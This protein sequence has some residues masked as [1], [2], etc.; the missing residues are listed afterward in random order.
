MVLQEL[1]GHLNDCMMGLRGAKNWEEH[2][3]W[4][5]RI[6]LLEEMVPLRVILLEQ[7]AISKKT[8]LDEEEE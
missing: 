6:G 3:H 7:D 4:M 5:S 2:I 8:K 1:E